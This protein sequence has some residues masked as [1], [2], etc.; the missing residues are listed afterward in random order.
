MDSVGAKATVAAPFCTTERVAARNTAAEVKVVALASKPKMGA[1]TPEYAF[2]SRREC[3]RIRTSTNAVITEEIDID[4][5]ILVNLAQHR[6]VDNLECVVAVDNQPQHFLR[7]EGTLRQTYI[8]LCPMNIRQQDSRIGPKF[9]QSEQFHCSLDLSVNIKMTQDECDSIGL[10]R[11]RFPFFPTA[12]FWHECHYNAIGE[13]AQAKDFDPYHN[14]L[15]RLLGLPLAEVEPGIQP[16][17]THE[18][19]SG[20]VGNSD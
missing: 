14:D 7:A 19:P 2:I 11:L 15:T 5:A 12:R 4:M 20:C 16:T 3:W 6:V 18:E 8:L 17:A 10:P 13:F 1:D 9:P